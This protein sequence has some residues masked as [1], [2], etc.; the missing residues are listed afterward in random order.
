M[1]ECGHTYPGKWSFSSPGHAPKILLI[2]RCFSINSSSCEH[3]WHCLSPVILPWQD[4]SSPWNKQ[5]NKQTDS[6]KKPWKYQKHS[7]ATVATLNSL[8]LFSRELPQNFP[9][10]SKLMLTGCSV[11]PGAFTA[12]DTLWFFWQ[13]VSAASLVCE[14]AHH[15]LLLMASK[16]TPRLPS[17]EIGQTEMEGR[18]I[19]LKPPPSK[20]YTL[21]N[22]I[23]IQ[24]KKGL[25]D[26]RPGL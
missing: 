17:L 14:G 24:L 7:M 15:L 1:R 23:D 9:F 18:W 26:I 16:G 4:F 5:T 2:G 13:A 3:H 6:T 21:I 20:I 8:P 12:Q 10:H 22:Y 19:T 11:L 25:M